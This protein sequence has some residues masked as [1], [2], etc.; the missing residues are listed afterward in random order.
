M[1]S[2]STMCTI[3]MMSMKRIPI[4]LVMAVENMTRIITVTIGKKMYSDLTITKL[5]NMFCFLHCTTIKR[6]TA[7][8]IP[9]PLFFSHFFSIHCEYSSV[10]DIVSLSCCIICQLQRVCNF[11]TAIY[12]FHCNTYIY[13]TFVYPGRIR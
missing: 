11:L 6:T 3:S 5:P 4:W 2:G 13:L 1:F 7:L 12:S 10:D 8:P 9:Q